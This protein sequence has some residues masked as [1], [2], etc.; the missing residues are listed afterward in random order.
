MRRLWGDGTGRFRTK[1]RRRSDG[2]RHQVADRGPLRQH[3]GDRQAGHGHRP[4]LRED[5]R[6]RSSRRATPTWPASTEEKDVAFADTPRLPSRNAPITLLAVAATALLGLAS[7]ASPR[8]SPTAPSR[9]A[10]TRRATSTHRPAAVIGVTYNAT[11]NDGTRSGCLCEGWGA[12][13]GGP[14]PSRP[15]QRGRRG[16]RLPAGVVHEQRRPAPS[17]SSTSCGGETPA[18]RLRRT[19]TVADHAEPLRDH[20]DAHEP[21]R[22]DADRRPLRAHHGLGHRA[23]ADRRVRHDQPRLAAARRPHLLRR[24]RLLGQLPVHDRRS[25]DGRSTPPPSTRTTTTR[26]RPTTA[27]ASRSRS[28]TLGAGRDEAVLRL[29]RRHRQRGGRERGRQRRGARDVLLRPAERPTA[30]LRPLGTPNTFIWGFRAVGG[31]PV[32]PPTLR[33]RRSRVERP[34]AARTRSRHAD[35]QR[36]DPVPGA[37]LVFPSAART[38][39][40]PAHDRRQ[41]PGAASATPAQRRR[42]HDHRL[43]GLQQQRRLRR[44]RG[45]RHGDQH[46]TPPP[47]PPPPPPVPPPPV[48]ELGKSV[49]AGMVSGTIKVKGKN[50]K[51][52]TLGANESIPLGSTIDATKGS[53]RLTSAAGP[54]GETQ[55]ARLLPGRVRGHA[56]QGRQADHPAR[57][58]RHAELPQGQEGDGVGQEEEGPAACGATARAASAPRAGARAA[59]VRGTKWLTEDRCTSTKVRVKRGVVSVRDFVKRKNVRRQEGPLVRGPEEAK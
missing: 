7:P 55:T 56:D 32:I 36:G 12:G 45:H 31:A 59:T 23:D 57:A 30:R 39:G 35:R 29:L 3:Q 19:S 42:R 34:P 41:R 20:H 4:R 16:T 51:F 18:L 8:R 58:H 38:G 37:E 53:V 25:G 52:R 11:G 26:A 28:A 43:P 47:P 21:Q 40:R 14:T 2:S 13:A 5:A 44:R 22:R 46:W 10:S 48:P 9:S 24:Q 6:T 1:G 15:R 27:R 17:R 33:C 50:G 54:G 49:V